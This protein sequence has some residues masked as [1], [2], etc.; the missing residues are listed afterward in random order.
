MWREDAIGEPPVA[1]SAAC[2]P[3]FDRLPSGLQPRRSNR[4][5]PELE[6]RVTP[7]KRGTHAISNRNNPHLPGSSGFPL[8]RAGI[9][10]FFEAVADRIFQRVRANLLLPVS[11]PLGPVIFATAHTPPVE[12]QP[13]ASP[14]IPPTERTPAQGHS[15][16][17]AHATQSIPAMGRQSLVEF[18]WE[19]LRRKN[20]TAIASRRGFRIERWTY[21]RIVEEASR[22]AREMEA[23]GVQR[24]DAVLLWG[25][26][27]PEWIAAFWGCLL[28]GA[29]VVP[30]DRVATPE[31]AGRVA[32]QVNAK[33]VIH[34]HQVSQDS[35]ALPNLV[36]ESLSETIAGHSAAP[37]VSPA[38]SRDDTLEIVFT[39]GTTAE[40]RGVVISHGNVLANI[41]PLEA[42]IRKYLRY[43]KPFHPLRFLNL[44]PLSHIF[45]Q[46]LAVFIPPLLGATTMF[47]DSL[48]PAEIAE[49]VRRERVS[50]LV[51]V[52]RLIESLQREIERDLE[53]ES[54][55]ERF[56]KDFETS[57]GRHFLRRWWRFRRIHSRLGWKFWAF[58]SG[59][60]ALPPAAET[61]WNRLGYAVIQGYGLT[62][63]TS[64]ISLNHPFR[65]DKG[66]IGKLF[67]G[68]EMKVGS[69]GEILVR[70]ENLARGYWRG[71]EL[72]PVTEEDGWFHTGDLAEVDKE[73]RLYF[74]GRMKNV[75]VTP[76][77]MNIYPEDL[78]RALR[79]QAG[80]K[81][82]VV[83]GLDRDGNAEPCAVLLLNDPDDDAAS[84]VAAANDS[85]AEFQRIRQ[86]LVWPELDFPRTP[87]LKP[88]LPRIRAAVEQKI[89]GAPSPKEAGSLVRLVAQITGQPAESLASTDALESRLNMSSLDR[90]ELMS[91]LEERYQIDLSEAKFADVTTMGQ[92]E[93]LLRDPPKAAVEMKYPRWP[94]SW[95]VTAFRIFVYYLLVWPA[96]YLL[97]SPRV[98]GREHL[99]RIRGPA[100]VISNHITYVDIGWILAALPM[101]LRHRLATAMRGERIE[102][103]IRP[104]ED[105]NFFERASEKL[106]YFLVFSLFNV[107]PLPRESGFR[108]SFA[109][110]G[111]LA[112]RGWSVLIFPEGKTTV[113]GTM[114]PFRAGIG[115]LAK[116]LN[117]PVVPMRLDGLFDMKIQNRILHRPGRVRVSIG[118]P[119]TFPPEAEAD[120]ISRDLESRVAALAWPEEG[121]RPIS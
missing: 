87:T 34:S 50:V 78:E 3:A 119:V 83:I 22:F 120:D 94:Q 102:T 61:F 71:Q 117:L 64:L 5:M 11:Y 35:P 88:L 95:P 66:S 90:V 33:L 39:S 40:P 28:R 105:M 41:E 69:D 77:G 51:A 60:A 2:A 29:V 104:P 47:L 84:V 106:S 101:K 92:L 54:G 65:S 80:V 6:F 74:K 113:D 79:A 68:I 116:Q 93:D 30:I 37:Y 10:S 76:A 20:E 13:E 55:L 8:F 97:A 21:G 114:Q 27:S 36:L 107:F 118:A 86:W 121:D 56:R 57:E 58:I 63:T 32:A 98:R 72:R 103:M 42:E 7:T 12:S 44:L 16:F 19:Y 110:V 70:G 52:P 38:L 23:R 53:R 67:P 43:E 18:F 4:N 45:G 48:N 96:T 108:R 46:L 31:F 14:S 100:L 15:N 26:N 49:A 112:D 89:H 115:L 1:L 109:F 17:Q 9:R 24:G 73:G 82:A 62:E 99:R 81:D 25:E 75:I 91:A 59:G 85:L 111:D